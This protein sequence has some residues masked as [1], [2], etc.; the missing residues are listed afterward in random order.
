MR[1]RKP[2]DFGRR[3]PYRAER[4]LFLIVCEGKET[5]P[6]YFRALLREL[7]LPRDGIV[8]GDTCGT[9]PC[10]V[11]EYAADH[12]DGDYAG[13][14]CV[15]DRDEH[16]GI[17]HALER[18]RALG[19]GV[20]FSNPCFELWYL[21]HFADCTRSLERQQ[22]TRE[23]RKHLPKYE[24]SADV[25]TD[26]LQGRE[27]AASLRAEAL[28]KRHAGVSEGWTANPSTSVDVMVRAIRD[29]GTKSTATETPTKGDT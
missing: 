9:H 23:L 25:Y 26:H 22:A 11:V 17:P 12:R 6:R 13:V 27:A 4:P 10:S 14:W 7:R 18:A 15:F 3:P 1:K 28:R 24:K 5:E 8:G 21:L 20:A 19:F 2:S 16:E 29:K